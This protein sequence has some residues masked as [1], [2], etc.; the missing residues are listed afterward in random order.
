[1]DKFANLTWKI[2]DFGFSTTGTSAQKPLSF[3]RKTRIYFSPELLLGSTYDAKSDIWSAGCILYQLSAGIPP[4]LNDEEVREYAW[5][6]K[7]APQV[8][9]ARRPLARVNKMIA[10]MLTSSAD[11]R[12]DAVNVLK[13]IPAQSKGGEVSI[14]I[15]RSDVERVK[16]DA[17]LGANRFVATMDGQEDNV[18]VELHSVSSP[19]SAID[20]NGLRMHVK[21]LQSLSESPNSHIPFCLGF[22]HNTRDEYSLIYRA[23]TSTYHDDNRYDTLEAVLSNPSHPAYKALTLPIHKARVAADLAWTLYSIHKAR[24]SHR[25]IGAHNVLIH[26]PLD[27][28]A[29]LMGFSVTTFQPLESHA[30]LI[31]ASLEWR[32]RLYQHPDCQVEDNF[33]FLQKYD[34]YALGVIM[35]EMGRMQS[36]G[37]LS[38]AWKEELENMNPE[39]LQWFRIKRAEELKDSV[40]EVYLDV[41]LRCLKGEFGQTG[42]DDVGQCFKVAVC[43]QLDSLCSS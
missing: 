25:M 16:C 1:M 14:E 6:R 10:D 22:I 2:T 5:S 8:I 32:D 17:N 36:F 19:I 40:D 30:E 38:G 4:F 43:E 39:K 12:P 41:M 21:L 35:L 23:P 26:S 15:S 20:C 33:K 29:S 13:C 3:G 37:L 18:I 31:T 11:K 42:P 28:H 34:Y 27:P 24:Y 9:D 7:P